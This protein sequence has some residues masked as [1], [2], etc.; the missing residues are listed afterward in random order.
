[1]KGGKRNEAQIGMKA[2]SRSSVKEE[3]YF[4]VE[5]C[6]TSAGFE[7]KLK[8]KR[9]DIKKCEQALATIGDVVGS[10]SVVL[11]AKIEGHSV[12]VYGSGRMMVKSEKRLREKEVHELAEK[13][14]AALEKFGGV[15]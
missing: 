13:M 5:P 1:M 8:D 6:T 7:I 12:S 15:I 9:F 14:M 2:A 4:V 11:V 10:T 3:A